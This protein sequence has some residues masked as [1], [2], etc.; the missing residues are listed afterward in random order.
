M[1]TMESWALSTFI[2]VILVVVSHAHWMI[3]KIDLKDWMIYIF[4]SIVDKN[5]YEG[6]RKEQNMMSD[7]LVP[8]EVDKILRAGWPSTSDGHF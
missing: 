4:N 7:S 1:F 5:K 8:Y 2:Q 3:L 6:W